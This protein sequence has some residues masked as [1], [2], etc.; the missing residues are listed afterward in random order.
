MMNRSVVPAVVTPAAVSG[1]FAAA[2]GHIAATA[3]TEASRPL[4][5]RRPGRLSTG[6][7][8]AAFIAVVWLALWA[9]V[10]V[11]VAAPLSRIGG[12]E[13]PAVQQSALRA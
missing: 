12:Q 10:S 4:F 7:L 11:G 9:W 5:A 3:P 8:P 2:T 1:A 6:P 13:R